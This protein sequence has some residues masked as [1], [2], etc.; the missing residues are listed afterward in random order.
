MADI[1]SQEEVDALL[2]MA[3]AGQITADEELS[4]P[5]EEISAERNVV[6][7]DFK[8]PNRVSK[9]QLKTFQT[10]HSSFATMFGSSLSAYLRTV[11]EIDVVTVDQL[12]YSEFIM[13]M[14]NPTSI[15]LF[16][17]FPLEGQAVME[18]SSALVFAIV[19][20]LLG[21]KGMSAVEGNRE[22]TLIEQSIIK[23]VILTALKD[24]QD[25]WIHIDEFEFQLSRYETNPQFVQ[26]ASPGDTVI[27]ISLDVK[28]PYVT[29]LVSVC[30]P[31]LMIEPVLSKFS[32]QIWISEIKKEVDEETQEKITRS[33]L[34]S[35][36]KLIA[37]LGKTELSV[38]EFLE[39]R[40]GDVIPLDTKV[41][42]PIKVKINDKIKYL[43]N[44]GIAEKRKAIKI[45]YVID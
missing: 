3:A 18:I 42:E 14:A 4:K 23:R 24:L 1:L 6:L 26:I 21:G 43:G 45:N 16:T 11:V 17:M 22:P 28:M 33:L 37:Q 8:R 12:T 10:L 36:V 7:Y 30:F 41:R 15:Y 34:E 35:N 38:R 20:R 44:L 2:E 27:L 19:D 32:T 39:L 9:D 40:K 25:A 5:A 13:S 31:F 29:G